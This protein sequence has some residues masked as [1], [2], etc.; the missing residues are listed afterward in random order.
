MF[1]HWNNFI[2]LLSKRGFREDPIAKFIGGN[3]LRVM[4]EV[5]P[6]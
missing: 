1:E 6:A 3:F 2:Q 5:L 4:R